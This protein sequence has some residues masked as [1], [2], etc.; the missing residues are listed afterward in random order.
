VD[1]I[2]YAAIFALFFLHG[3]RLRARRWFAGFSDVKL[4]VTILAI[5]FGLFPLI[6]LA[7]YFAAPALLDPDDLDRLAVL[8]VVPSTVQSSI[9]YTSMA[10]GNVAGA[11]AAAA[12]SIGRVWWCAACS[13]V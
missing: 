12:F 2:T 1:V 8:C 9:A 7:M 13:R 5:T 4:H 10:D 6:G 3:A 11:V